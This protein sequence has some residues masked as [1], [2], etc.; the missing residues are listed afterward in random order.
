MSFHLGDKEKKVLLG[1]LSELVQ[2]PFV[3]MKVVKPDLISKVFS[4]DRVYLY[5]IKI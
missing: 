3:K 4:S 1:F 5:W 2:K